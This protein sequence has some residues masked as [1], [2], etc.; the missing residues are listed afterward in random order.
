MRSMGLEPITALKNLIKR[1]FWAGCS[2]GN[3]VGNIT[4]KV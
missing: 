3:R 1:R 4:V 2:V